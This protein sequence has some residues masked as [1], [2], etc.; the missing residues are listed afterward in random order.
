M[1]I[2]YRLLDLRNRVF[3]LMCVYLFMHGTRAKQVVGHRMLTM[4]H[5]PSE[6]LSIVYL[7]HYSTN[8]HG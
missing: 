2:L 1:V 8:I 7:E 4:A 6:S 3:L 5:P